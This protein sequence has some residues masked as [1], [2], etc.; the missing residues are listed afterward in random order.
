VVTPVEDDA[1]GI[2]RPAEGL[3]RFRLDR[4]APSP[5]LARFVDRFWVTSWDLPDGESHTQE[6]LAHPGVNLVLTA[7]FATV[8]GVSTGVASR[9]ISGRGRA[10]GVLFRPAGFRPYLGRPLAT[11]TDTV[12]PAAEIVGPGIAALAGSAEGRATTDVVADLDDLLSRLAPDDPQP[13][14]RTSVLVE[15]IAADPARR[16]E[17]VAAGAGLSMRQ[18]QRRFADHVGLNPKGVL[19]RYRLF[20]A[21]E[22]VRRDG[23]VDWAA[24]AAELRYSDQPHLVRDFHATFGTPPEAYARACASRDRN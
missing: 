6:V 23:D 8:T 16:V 18:L 20:E 22:R 4:Y 7:G 17:A 19:R 10:V 14:E 3:S 12:V 24:L 1:R 5:R 2:I 11:I 21:A 15:G 13:S 9:T